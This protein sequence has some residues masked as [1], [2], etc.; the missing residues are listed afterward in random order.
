MTTTASSGRRHPP[1]AIKRILAGTVALGATL[2]ASAGMAAASVPVKPLGVYQADGVTPLRSSGSRGMFALSVPSDARCPGDSSKSPW[3]NMWSY[4]VPSG[5]D[6]RTVHF[7]GFFPDKGLPLIEAGRYFGPYPVEKDSGRLHTLPNDFTMARFR[8]SDFLSNGARSATWD[9]GIVCAPF[10]GEAVDV[11]HA[12]IQ[13]TA[14][15]SDP[16][17]YIWS[18]VRPSP[19]G[20]QHVPWP[21]VGGVAAA[22][23]L[24]SL[25]FFSGARRP[26]GR[27]RTAPSA[28]P[29]RRVGIS[30]LVKSTT[31]PGDPE[32]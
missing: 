20:H 14:S 7:K 9:M 22:F 1:S 21:A 26:S 13:V 29:G 6:I 10:T 16:Q 17:G 11:W 32:S 18:A 12:Q 28:E 30:D 25:L 5:T 31:S 2:F 8:A 15:S 4:L 19:S 3:Y 24:G 27:S 23:V